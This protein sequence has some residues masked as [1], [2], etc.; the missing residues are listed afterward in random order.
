M[1]LMNPGAAAGSGHVLPLRDGA[2]QQLYQEAQAA[3]Y[4]KNQNKPC[5]GFRSCGHGGIP[6]R[7]VTQRTYR[8]STF[9]LALETSAADLTA[10]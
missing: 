1:S 10:P 7:E 6:S 9:F 8:L 5:Q 3:Q 2:P 4:A